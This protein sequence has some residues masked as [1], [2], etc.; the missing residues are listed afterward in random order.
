MKRLIF[1][2]VSTMMLFLAGCP[3]GD[4]GGGN[5]GTTRAVTP[6]ECARWQQNRG[7]GYGGY[8]SQYYN[9][10]NYDYYRD[11]IDYEVECR[12]YQ[13]QWD[14]SR[15]DSRFWN[16][17]DYG[18]RFAPI[19]IQGNCALYGP[20][21]IAYQTGVSLVCIDTRVWGGNVGYLN[22]INYNQYGPIYQGC[23]VGA[24]CDCDYGSGSF[25]GTLGWEYVLC[26]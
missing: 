9:Y 21:W 5:G 1:W 2:T 24:D 3:G 12:N 6:F 10:N 13:G 20:T 22:V 16:H 17:P 18:R 11:D 23:R 4:G 25:G 8:N 14:N 19:T 7:T 26:N 15:Y